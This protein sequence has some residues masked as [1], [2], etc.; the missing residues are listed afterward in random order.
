MSGGNVE[1]VAW[2]GTGM[3]GS[4]FVEGMLSRGGAVDVWNR[5]GNKA[6]ALVA[7]GAT[8]HAQVAD[9]VKDAARIHLCLSDDEAVDGV[10][11]QV[12][13]AMKR[14]A[15]VVDHTTVSPEGTARRAE[16]MAQAGVTFVHAPVFMAPDNARTATGLMLVS[17]P[18]DV[19]D[20]VRPVLQSMTGKLIELGARAD[21][22]AA[23]K[24]F[25]NC[26][27]VALAAGLADMLV[28]ARSTGID[29]E[30]AM[31]LFK[32]FQVAGQI[33]GRGARMAKGDFA[34]SFEL[35]MARKDVR[36]M[37]ETARAAPSLPLTMLPGVADRMDAL[38]AAGHG[39]KDLAVLALEV[40]GNVVNT[41]RRRQP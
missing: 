11:A 2:L 39:E 26:V 16:R 9:A 15:L 21:K 34:P 32:D 8:P 25:G 14:G 24:L 30:E 4:G 3:L 19:V 22:A 33:N 31:G 23:F 35:S 7:K 41:G 18:Q 6:Q 38:L 40:F 29:P 1:R 37:Q 13:P 12:L 28:L 17:G 5:T 27:I 10:L 36:L 20:R